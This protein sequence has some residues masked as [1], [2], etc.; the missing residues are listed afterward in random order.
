MPFKIALLC[1]QLV[2]FSLSHSAVIG[3]SFSTEDS[4]ELI[5]LHFRASQRACLV[6]LAH[7]AHIIDRTPFSLNPS[8]LALLLFSHSYFDKS[9]LPADSSTEKIPIWRAHVG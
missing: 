3:T 1:H 7:G 6:D 9:V 4:M 5:D 2:L 8:R